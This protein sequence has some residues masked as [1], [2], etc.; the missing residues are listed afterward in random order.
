MKLN[1]EKR[2]KCITLFFYL[3]VI[4]VVTILVTDVNDVP[5]EFVGAP[6]NATVVEEEQGKELLVR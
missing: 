5:P 2:F 3:Q 1:Q 4:G 6:Y